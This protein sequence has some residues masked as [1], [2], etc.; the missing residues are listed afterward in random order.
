MAE[1]GVNIINRLS[2]SSTGEI[3]ILP[4]DAGIILSCGTLRRI[5]KMKVLNRFRIVD[6][7]VHNPIHLSDDSNSAESTKSKVLH[8]QPGLTQP[9]LHP[10]NVILLND[11][12]S[13]GL[14]LFTWAKNKG[15]LSS[16]SSS[17]SLMISL[18]TYPALGLF[19]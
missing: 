8:G 12:H 10:H 17:P 18:G 5:A 7:L 6:L 16:I 3:G 2:L 4:E 14:G 1:K 11:G 9:I 13:A 15:L 19:L